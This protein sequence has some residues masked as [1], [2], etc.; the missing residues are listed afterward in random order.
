MNSEGIGLIPLRRMSCTWNPRSSTGSGIRRAAHPTP[1]EERLN[2]WSVGGASRP[3]GSTQERAVLT[4]VDQF[5][6]EI[7]YML[8][9]PRRSV[10]V[11]WWGGVDGR[12]QSGSNRPDTPAAR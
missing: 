2:T 6:R 12:S 3:D 5:S 10:F 11:Q 4:N 9:V 8:P 7:P 1:P